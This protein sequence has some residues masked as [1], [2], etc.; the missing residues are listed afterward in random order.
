MSEVNAYVEISGY[1]LVVGELPTVVQGQRV[2]T[3]LMG[4][5]TVGDALMNRVSG[6]VHGMRK[7]RISGL[8]F[9]QRDDRAPVTLADEGIAFPIAHTAPAI[10]NGRTILETWLGM[11]PRRV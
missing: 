10:D 2:N 9:D 11:Q 1:V 3:H 4:R 7:K 5:K 6:L 8:S